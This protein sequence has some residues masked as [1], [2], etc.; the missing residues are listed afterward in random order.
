V[1]LRA[2]EQ[3]LLADVSI[4]EPWSLVECFAT[5]PREDPLD[6]ARGADEI[7]ARLKALGIPCTVHEPQLFLGLPK[8]SRLEVGGETFEAKPS[9]FV[10]SFPEGLLGKVVFVDGHVELT[11]GFGPTTAYLFGPDATAA[12][13]VPDVRGCIAAYRGLIN[14]ER[15]AQFGALGAIAVI[16]INPGENPHWGGG[17]AFWG[18]P[19]TDDM[20]NKP[21]IPG[22]AVNRHAGERLVA[23]AKSGGTVRLV[24]DSREGWFKSKLPVVEIPGTQNPQQFLLLH[25]HY[26]AWEV[27][28]GDNATGNAAMLEIARV[29]WKHRDKLKRSI[30]LA[31]WPGHSTGRFAG[32]TW[33]A[34]RF[35]LD[36]V[37]N[38]IAQVNCD[39][40][41]CRWATSYENIPW[42]A[43]NAAF[44]ADA[45][46]DAV[47]KPSSGRR[48]PPAN[49]YSFNNLGVTGYLSSSSRIPEEEVKRRG[50]Y[51]VIGNGGN[52][53][54]HTK[55]DTLEVA[56]RDILLD[57]I[58]VY[59]LAVYRNANADILPYDWGA[60]LGEFSSTVAR[61]QQVTGDRFD[62][63]PVGDAIDRLARLVETF[64]AAAASG[65]I[66]AT[67][68]NQ[69]HIELSR[70][71]VRL[72]YVKGTQ[73]T[74]DLAFPPHPLPW[75]AIARDLDRY[76][77]A[78]VGFAL[79]Q[80][81]RGANAV[82]GGLLLARRAVERALGVA[83]AA[84]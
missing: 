59:L 53:E 41:G 31:W 47:G 23:A 35:A 27:G 34:D 21:G 58:K 32:S 84:A 17:C 46:K 13:G 33:Y 28:V 66:S 57:D 68:A 19:G 72:N 82:M 60:L 51:W 15:I 61:Y 48:P 77:P 25:G 50:Y 12:P 3:A 7:A 78:T 9:S 40:P 29:L 6:V 24:T 44:V 80:L 14:A 69:V 36:I 45:V 11:Q 49:D 1:G 22:V 52:I 38:C 16:A 75:L 2:D 18:S 64:A 74:R 4:A 30:R 20:I 43:E 79:T 10:P 83:G 56:D 63:A 67:A 42:M 26:D 37:E 70:H 65:R 54:W 55:Y 8:P 71:L 73:Y 5:M 76:T 39:S 81:Q 62:F